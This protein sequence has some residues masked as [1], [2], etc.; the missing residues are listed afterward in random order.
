M[1]KIFLILFLACNFVMH[2][3]SVFKTA[4]YRWRNDN[5]TETSATWKAATN[6][7]ITLTSRNQNIRLRLNIRCQSSFFPA[8]PN[9]KVSYSKNGGPQ[10]EITND[11][12]KDFVLSS[13]SFVATQTTTTNQLPTAYTYVNGYFVSDISIPPTFNL[14]ANQSTEVEFC[15][16]ATGAASNETTYTFYSYNSSVTYENQ[17]ASLT[18]QFCVTPLTPTTNFSS[19]GINYVVTSPTTAAVADNTLS[20]I[21]I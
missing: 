18:T 21:H 3:F 9:T 11:T 15:I 16:R 7:P 4:N 12:S 10:V 17:P 5:G 8:S 6:N 2:A 14:I 20:L 19:D 13:S 1:K